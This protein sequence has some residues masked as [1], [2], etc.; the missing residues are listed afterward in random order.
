MIGDNV[1]DGIGIGNLNG[2]LELAVHARR[3]RGRRR[4][5]TRELNGKAG[6]T[7]STDLECGVFN[8]GVRRGRS[9]SDHGRHGVQNIILIVASGVSRQVDLFGQHVLCAIAVGR[10]ASEELAVLALHGGG[11][12]GADFRDDH[13]QTVFTFTDHTDGFIVG[14]Q[15]SRFVNFY[16]GR[17]RVHEHAKFVVALDAFLLDFKIFAS[18][19]RRQGQLL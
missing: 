10:H 6:F 18:V 14:V 12:I 5:R 19:T 11:L 2:A 16:F 9:D 1:K 7:S 15:R 17:R 4:G 3:G 13:I 8:D